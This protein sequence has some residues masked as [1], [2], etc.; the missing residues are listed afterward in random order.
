MNGRTGT[1]RDDNYFGQP[2]F[3]VHGSIISRVDRRQI[4]QIRFQ[5]F[6]CLEM[7]LSIS[8]FKMYARTLVAGKNSHG[9]KWQI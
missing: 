7:N 5:F 4:F 8:D 9:V 2:F 3:P 1:Q 6:D